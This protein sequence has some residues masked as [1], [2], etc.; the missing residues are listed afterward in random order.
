MWPRNTNGNTQAT[1]LSRRSERRSQEDSNRSSLP[2]LNDPDTPSTC[3]FVSRFPKRPHHQAERVRPPTGADQAFW[4]RRPET[5]S[6]GPSQRGVPPGIQRRHR[7]RNTA[8]QVG[9]LAPP[10]LV[11]GRFPLSPNRTPTHT[12]H[13]AAG[14]I[15]SR[16]PR[17]RDHDRLPVLPRSPL[18]SA[19]QPYRSRAGKKNPRTPDNCTPLHTARLLDT[20]CVHG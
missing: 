1:S 3:S 9:R 2:R 6:H 17:R 18:P 14:P 19:A 11:K 15:P 5:T 12:R 4:R 13:R 8:M 10:H 7:V 16:H 20:G